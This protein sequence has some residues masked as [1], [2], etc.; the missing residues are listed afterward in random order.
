MRRT[1]HELQQTHTWD[2]LPGWEPGQCAAFALITAIVHEE[3]AKDIAA[4]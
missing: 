1:C 3:S 4:W 2:L